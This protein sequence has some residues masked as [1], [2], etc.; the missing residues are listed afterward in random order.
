M[1]IEIPQKIANNYMTVVFFTDAFEQTKNCFAQQIE[2]DFQKNKVFESNMFAVLGCL[3]AT[4]EQKRNIIKLTHI[5]DSIK[6]LF[7]TKKMNANKPVKKAWQ[8]L[9]KCQC[10]NADES[11][12]ISYME[13][14]IFPERVAFK[15]NEQLKMA[16]QLCVAESF[17]NA[18]THA[19]C[20]E[21]FIA[22]YF[23]THNKKLRITI[24][25]KGKNMKQ[26]I[27]GKYQAKN[28]IDA[29]NW[30]VQPN[31][32]GSTSQAHQGIGLPTIRQFIAQNEGKIKIVS[33]NAVWKQ[34]K[35]RIFS[36]EQPNNFS[37]TLITLEFA[38]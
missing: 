26:A 10:L 18:F 6:N 32:T 8:L 4:L 22:H 31:N 25:N 12:L 2:I 3:I 21:I 33:G 19:N 1:T 14:R 37:G 20:H 34:V 7:N 11:E 35:H 29:I 23:S 38:I 17:R 30:A 36:K 24:V 15:I 28:F 16:I 9:V 27:A 5:P 13:Q